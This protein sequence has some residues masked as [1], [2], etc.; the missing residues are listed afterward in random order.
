MK[1]RGCCEQYITQFSLS[2]FVFLSTWLLSH[3]FETM[4]CKVEFFFFFF[5]LS[6]QPNTHAAIT[7]GPTGLEAANSLYV[8]FL[9]FLLSIYPCLFFLSVL[10]IL[11]QWR[12]REEGDKMIERTPPS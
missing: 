2:I 7:T 3:Y 1:R 8:T 11:K 10:Q 4:D 5:F 6:Q 12:G 9:C